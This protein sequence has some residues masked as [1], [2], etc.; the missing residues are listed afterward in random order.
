MRD[1]VV[2]LFSALVFAGWGA[3][4]ALQVFSPSTIHWA[5]SVSNLP[6][7]A[8]ILVVLLFDWLITLVLLSAIFT[9]KCD[10]PADKKDEKVDDIVQ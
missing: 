9:R 1:I 10:T 4:T 2:T 5:W 8:G 6:G 7:R 3:L